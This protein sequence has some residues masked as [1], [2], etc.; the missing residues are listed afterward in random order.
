MKNRV[1]KRVKMWIL[2]IMEGVEDAF[3]Q[4]IWYTCVKFSKNIVSRKVRCK[5]I[6]KDTQCQF[7]ACIPSRTPALHRNTNIHQVS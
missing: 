1:G 4:N 5:V 2:R 6:G 7:L 3:D